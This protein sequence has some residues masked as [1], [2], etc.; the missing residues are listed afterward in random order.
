MRREDI[1]DLEGVQKAVHRDK[2]VWRDVRED[3]VA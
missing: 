1:R 3:S 2:R